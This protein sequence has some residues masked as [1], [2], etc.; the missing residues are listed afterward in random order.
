MVGAGLACPS[1]CKSRKRIKGRL[2]LS[3]NWAKEAAFILVCQFRGFWSEIRER[4]DI[5]VPHL[6]SIITTVRD[7]PSILSN[8]VNKVKQ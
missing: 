2:R 1:P 5:F 6:H 4:I 8:K 3:M 7:I